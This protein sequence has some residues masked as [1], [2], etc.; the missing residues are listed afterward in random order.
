MKNTKPKPKLTK[1]GLSNPPIIPTGINDGSNYTLYNTANYKSKI[2]NSVSDILFKF[3]EVLLEYM[4]FMC[5]K[6][7][8]KNNTRY[9]YIVERGIHTLMHVFSIMFVS[10]K[11]L[12]LSYY[13]TQ[14]AFYFYVEFI[15]QISDE[16]VTYLHLS[17]RDAT[18][19]VYKKTI[20]ALNNDFKLT[21]EEKYI[22]SKV[23]SI[24]SIYKNIIVYALNNNDLKY[25]HI[26]NTCNAIE[27]I[28]QIIT[29]HTLTP[30]YIECIYLFTNLLVDKGIQVPEFFQ[31]IADFSKI[32][33]NE[34]YKKGNECVIKH[35]IYNLANVPELSNIVNNILVDY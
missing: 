6:I 2:V 27:T 19:F 8:I 11:N 18:L 31:L 20:F 15:E 30:A 35:N 22:M 25:D 26:N 14:K 12:E 29:E 17:S 1:N 24:M 34:T 28:N 3:T 4:R 13:Y 21:S 33:T 10:T 16:S 9:R 7:I 32:I 5:D 23:D